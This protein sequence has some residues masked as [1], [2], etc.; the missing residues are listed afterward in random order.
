MHKEDKAP[1]SESLSFKDLIDLQE[2]QKIQDSFSAITNVGVHT[3]SL[4]GTALTSPSGE[5]RLC[6]EIIKNSVLKEKING[7]CVPTFLGGRSVVDKNLSFICCAG[8][9]SFISPISLAN[10]VIGYIIVGPVILV[11]RKPKEQYL[12]EAEELG[13]ELDTLWNALLEIK[14]ISFHSVQSLVEIIKD[15]CEYM[16][17][18]SYQSL[19]PKDK[20]LVTA[21]PSSNK[22]LDALL[23][24]AFQVSGADIGSIMLVDDNRQ[25][26]SIYSS[27]G[28]S[29]EI[30]KTSRVK[31]GQG[32]SGM[33][34]R[35][36]ATFVIDTNKQDNRIK[37]YLNRPI[38]GSSMVIPINSGD[39]VLGVMNLGALESSP[40][41]F[42]NNNVNL[43]N[44]L[45]GLATIAL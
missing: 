28:L 22:I 17:K 24:V 38:L 10:K 4:N 11:M 15:I 36:N 14:V 25:E 35:D 12:N 39:R 20:D 13:I 27:K 9:H 30:A 44:R 29:E 45:I 1:G 2:W 40:T 21:S 42:D 34:A 26:L 3:L 23:D 18:L 41:R 32:I 31:I 19:M 16:L 5:P 43:I 37:E 7:L 8:M 33:A 6:K